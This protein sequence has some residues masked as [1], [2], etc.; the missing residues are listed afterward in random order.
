M[1][2]TQFKKWLTKKIENDPIF[3]R[4]R[5]KNKFFKVCP[6][7]EFPFDTGPMH[8]TSNAANEKRN[9]ARTMQ[10]AYHCECVLLCW[11]SQILLKSLELFLSTP[12]SIGLQFLRRF[13]C[14]L[15]VCMSKILKIRWKCADNLH[16]Y[17][18]K[19]EP[20]EIRSSR[21]P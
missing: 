3:R 18:A 11:S 8:S 13:K 16:I 5:R 20:P 12:T 2:C 4:E 9:F 6:L 14:V 19:F 7:S 10:N 17:G 21:S 15:L 1:Y